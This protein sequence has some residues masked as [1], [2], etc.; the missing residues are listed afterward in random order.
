MRQRPGR[1]SPQDRSVAEPGR[2]RRRSRDAVIA[3][4]LRRHAIHRNAGPWLGRLFMAEALGE[5]VVLCEFHGPRR[6]DCV[7]RPAVMGVIFGNCCDICEVLARALRNWVGWRPVMT[8][9]APG[10]A[11]PGQRRNLVLHRSARRSADPR[12]RRDQFF[13]KIL[14]SFDAWHAASEFAVVWTCAS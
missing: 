4:F 12:G 2:P 9:G 5:R 1:V 7:A 11:G 13:R 3:T 6:Q 8:S 14:C 10:A